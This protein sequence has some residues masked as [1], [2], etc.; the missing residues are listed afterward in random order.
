MA[1]MPAVAAAQTADDI[2][3]K[4]FAARGGLQAIRAVMSERV[5]GTISFGPGADGPFM[6]ERKRPLK[7]HME[8]TLGGATLIRVY[9]GKS[10]GWTYNPFM[11]NPKVEPMSESELR[12]IT[13]E[14]DFEGPFIDYKAKGNKV[15]FAGKTVVE[16]KPAY[17]IKLTDKNG[18]VSYFSFDAATYLLLL[19]QGNRRTGDKD[20]P[21]ESFFREF[22]EVK[23]L[24][25]PFL[26]ES[27]APGT[28]QIQRIFAD[29]IEVNTPIDESRFTKPAPPPPPTASD[30]PPASKPGSKP[31]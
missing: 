27:N 11:P 6:V 1:L 31:N 24:M 15:E 23:G 21:W 9:D 18:E 26:I 14:S 12:N 3:N 4:Y 8:V 13:D 22:R 17:K 30:P 5:T 25:Y 20:V 29:K 16:G 19:W 2:L 28:E 10:Q 7:M